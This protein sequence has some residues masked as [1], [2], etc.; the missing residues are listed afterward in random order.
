MMGIGEAKRLAR[1]QMAAGAKEV[2]ND[3]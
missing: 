1:E 3:K 2:G